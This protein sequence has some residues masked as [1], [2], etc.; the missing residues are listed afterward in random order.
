ML[1]T[2]FNQLMAPAAKERNLAGLAINEGFNNIQRGRAY[3]LGIDVRY[4]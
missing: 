3:R 2:I 1:I 4:V